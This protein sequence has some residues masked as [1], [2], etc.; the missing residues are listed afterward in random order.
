MDEKFRC[1]LC[2]D[3]FNDPRILSCF[4]T[5]CRDCLKHYL[6]KSTFS[7]YLGTSFDCPLCRTRNHL[8]SGGVDSLQKN[9]Y[10]DEPV[11]Q[12]VEPSFQMCAVHPKEDLRFFCCSCRQ[13]ICR[14]C[15]IVSHEGHETDMVDNVGTAMR[16]TLEESLSDTKMDIN[17]IETRLTGAF[18]HK[19]NELEATMAVLKQNAMDIKKEID[20]I[21][22]ETLGLIQPQCDREKRTLSNIEN[23]AEEKRKQLSEYKE[24]LIEA[25]ETKKHDS[26]FKLFETLIDQEELERMKTPPA[27]PKHDSAEEELDGQRLKAAF[28]R[29]T[30]TIMHGLREF[31]TKDIRQGQVESQK[32]KRFDEFRTSR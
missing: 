15:K 3:R 24:L 8:P 22:E 6:T 1:S 29:L 13:C 11:K 20:S 27:M 30:K 32:E 9:F 17:E 21:L 12:E 16:L 26:I 28:Q 19:I 18:A 31:K 2:L 23:H 7:A 14:D 25:I 4:H 5:F 10:L